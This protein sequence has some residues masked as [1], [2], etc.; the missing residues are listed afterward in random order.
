[1]RN[2]K[3]QVAFSPPLQGVP[4]LCFPDLKHHQSGEP[5]RQA[6]VSP[7]LPDRI[8]SSIRYHQCPNLHTQ[9]TQTTVLDFSSGF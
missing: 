8:M 6:V 7:L 9:K 2:L 1:M 3:A 5:E 4:Q